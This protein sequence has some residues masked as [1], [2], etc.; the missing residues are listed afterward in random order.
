MDIKTA[1]EAFATAVHDA[2]VDVII[3]AI[4]L[5][6][7]VLDYVAISINK[8]FGTKFTGEELG[9]ALI[10]GQLI[11]L[12]GAIVVVGEGIIALIATFGAIPIA[13]GAAVAIAVVALRYFGV[14]WKDVFAI[15]VGFAAGIGPL[16]DIVLLALG[17]LDNFSFDALKQEFQSFLQ[18]VQG[19]AETIN[20]LIKKALGALPHSAKDFTD[21]DAAVAQQNALPGRGDNPQRELNSQQALSNLPNLDQLQQKVGDTVGNLSNGGNAIATGAQALIDSS[22]TSGQHLTTSAKNLITSAGALK[23]AAG[24]LSGL[25]QALAPSDQPQNQNQQQR[26]LQGNEEPTYK[27]IG[28]DPQTGQQFPINPATG[29]FYAEGGPVQGKPGKDT[30][31]SWLTAGEFVMNTSAVGRYGKSFMHAVNNMRLPR[32]DLG[33]LVGAGTAAISGGSSGVQGAFAAA[34]G[35]RTFNLVFADASFSGLTG[36]DRTMQH[37]ESYAASRA[38]SQAGRA[39]SNKFK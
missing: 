9:I 14:A 10:I 19:W 25:L 38:G 4:Q 8:V 28:T 15:V 33:G 1:V 11:G 24:S 36:P 35:N 17:G 13:I 16:V 6:I 7:T 31:L 21:V 22:S 2:F 18:F 30:N 37:L 23:D 12:N 32:F 3:P 26:V 5:A 20:D 27:I 34:S 29:Q 39:R